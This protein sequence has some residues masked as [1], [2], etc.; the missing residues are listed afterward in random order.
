[1]PRK[2]KKGQID[3]ARDI[4]NL[5]LTVWLAWHSSLFLR[6]WEHEIQSHTTISTMSDREVLFFVVVL[7]RENQCSK[8]ST[9]GTSF[10]GK[11]CD[12]ESTKG[13]DAWKDLDG[14]KG[15]GK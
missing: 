9:Y 8:S 1:M 15:R 7:S 4:E 10:N 12:H 13:G 14:G 3:A 6:R 2:G 11:I 5:G